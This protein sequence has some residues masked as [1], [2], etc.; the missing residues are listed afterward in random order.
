MIVVKNLTKYINN[1]LLW[2]DVS[3]VLHRGD[4]IGLVGR[5]GCGKSTLLKIL[6]GVEKS[7]TGSVNIE[8]EKIGYLS[9]RVIEDE[10]ISIEKFFGNL[11]KVQVAKMMKK[12]GLESLSG[13]ILL[14]SLSG[15]QKT[16]LG[17][18]KILAE[19]PTVL[20]LD[21]PTN[22]L[23]LEGLEWLENMI[24][25]FFGIVLVISHDR[26]LL[27]N[28]V[29]EVWEI[30]D[31]NNFFQRYKGNYSE[32]L[33]AR[34][35]MMEGWENEYKNQQKEKKRLENLLALKR[36]EAHVY[37]DPAKGKQVRALEKRIQR[38]IYDQYINR[39]KEFDAM[40]DL[41]F[42][43]EIPNSKLVLRVNNIC[44]S[45]GNK[46]VVFG[47]N[48]EIRGKERV[49]LAGNNGSGKSTLIKII[50]GEVRSDRGEVKIGENVKVGYFAQGQETLNLDRNIID[51]FLSVEGIDCGIS[52]AR[53]ILGAFMFSGDDVY[54][55]VG[56]L[57]YGERVRLMF[58]KLVNQGNQFL[59][60]DEPTNHLDIP[61]REVIEDALNN[62]RG[63]LLLV[64]HDR[65]F[66]E[67]VNIEKTITLPEGIVS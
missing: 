7:D 1:E 56:V 57:S 53:S 21:E 2:K 10:S 33:L 16:K 38:E 8:Q 67:K 66:I 62:Y 11:D 17:L 51:E 58:A 41:R 26:R 30:D 36:Q 27:D 54:K 59:I 43:E 45:F 24:H 63:A 13:N 40:A 50:T 47:I 48:L 49:L 32:Y 23:D 19:R 52:R 28:V 60:L 22:N 65:Y 35:K 12:V 37:K 4:K 34:G 14:K 44:K 46:S 5:N 9:Q 25:E 61:S 15:G 39:P 3:F 18:A 20:L 64:S 42:Q 55:K 6:S 31:V 29:N